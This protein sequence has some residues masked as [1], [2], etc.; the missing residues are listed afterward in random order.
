MITYYDDFYKLYKTVGYGNEVE[1]PNKKDKVEVTSYL[2]NDICCIK[3]KS[4]YSQKLKVCHNTDALVKELTYKKSQKK[5]ETTTRKSPTKKDCDNSKKSAVSKTKSDNKINCNNLPENDNYIQTN[6]YIVD[7]E[8]GEVVSKCRTGESLRRSWYRQKDLVFNN[9]AWRKS[10]FITATLDSKPTYAKMNEIT[11][12]FS[13]WLKRKYSVKL[14]CGFIFLEPCE[15]G[16]WHVHFIIAFNNNTPSH[17][18]ESVIK[19]WNKRNTKFCS[20]QV[21]IRTFADVDDLI[22]TVY[23]LNPNSKKKRHK[24]GFYPVSGQPM[25]HFGDVTEPNRVLTDFETAEKIAGSEKPTMRKK[26]EVV[27]DD[28]TLLFSSSEYYYNIELS[29]LLGLQFSESFDNS[30]PDNIIH[31]NDNNVKP[32]SKRKNAEKRCSFNDYVYDNYTLRYG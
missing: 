28:N 27:A 1:L 7:M 15:D 12:T 6:G 17:F 18:A 2:A 20:E 3:K 26:F 4:I 19:W 30:E 31:Q 25:R 11:A 22:Q 23:Y 13:K 5:H 9:A 24:V 8:T 16:S 32:F 10:L 29:S 14:K 21:E